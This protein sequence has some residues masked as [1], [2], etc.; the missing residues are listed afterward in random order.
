LLDQLIGF[1]PSDLASDALRAETEA[2]RTDRL[3]YRNPDPVQP[4]LSALTEKLRDALNN[5]KL[6]YNALYDAQMEALQAN[7]Y[8]SKL[9]PEQKHPILVRHQLIAKPELKPLDAQGLLLQLQKISLD[10]W[11]TKIAA[12]PGQ[13]QA[14]VDE[15]VQLLAPQAKA[16]Y[17]PKRTLNNQ[18]DIEAYVAELKTQ[19]EAA[20][21]DA[22]S[23]ILK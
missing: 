18:A 1:A 9:A 4:L 10:G 23:I 12:L 7:E 20:L 3:L 5:L 21:K 15:A 17:L 13:F 14:A 6:R 11:H 2:I 22:A 19:L 8:F 16:F